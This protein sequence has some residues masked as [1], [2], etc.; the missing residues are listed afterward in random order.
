MDDE[1]EGLC[2]CTGSEWSK[3][4]EPWKVG[5]KPTSGWDMDAGPRKSYA[6]N[7]DFGRRVEQERFVQHSTAAGVDFMK[8]CDPCKAVA[9]WN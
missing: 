7:R 5:P 3:E 1:H 2:N 4:E 8:C 6:L 9:N